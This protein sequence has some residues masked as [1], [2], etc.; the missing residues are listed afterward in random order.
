MTLAELIK[1][2]NFILALL[3]EVKEA[4]AEDGPGLMS[5][6]GLKGETEE[7]RADE[8][9]ALYEESK[10]LKVKIDK[11]K[12]VATMTVDDDAEP[13]VKTIHTPAEGK[14]FAEANKWHE[15]PVGY[16]AKAMHEVQDIKD[17]FDGK[18]NMHK[19]LNH[20]LDFSFEL[21]KATLTA[22]GTIQF[23]G[24]HPGHRE[25]GPGPGRDGVRGSARGDV[26]GAGDE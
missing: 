25:Y 21:T 22:A 6:N 15:D 4:S 19:R 18:N 14:V 10:E 8:A 2:Y 3:R 16:M 23:G 9:L 17:A 5:V 1:R 11:A 24:G 20:Y 26:P 12:T 7:E 13:L